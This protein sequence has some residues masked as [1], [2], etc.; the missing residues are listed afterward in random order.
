MNILI[1]KHGLA[2]V[3]IVFLAYF[4]LLCV[5]KILGDN[6]FLSVLTYIAFAV[7]FSFGYWLVL[8]TGNPMSKVNVQRNSQ[9]CNGISSS[10]GRQSGMDILRIVA[11]AEVILIHL[12][13]NGYY[14]TPLMGTRMFFLTIIRWILITCVP[15]FFLISGY[16]MKDK[17]PCLAFYRKIVLL[18][19][20]YIGGFLIIY[21]YNA[22]ILKQAT[23][24]STIIA[25]ILNY[26]VSGF[27][28]QYV[29][30]FFLIPFLN[31]IWSQCRRKSMHQWL[32]VTFLMI[33]AVAPPFPILVPDIFNFIYPITYYFV[34]A[35]IA[36]YRPHINK[37]W[38]I[39]AIIL[40][41]TL[42]S[43][44]SYLNADANG[45]FDW[46]FMSY[47]Q[48][49]YQ[50][51]PVVVMT[52]MIALLC[53]DISIRAPR[54]RH[55]LSFF[56]GLS[57]EIYLF[58]LPVSVIICNWLGISTLDFP[59]KAC[60]FPLVTLGTLIL[61][62]LAGKLLQRGIRLMYKLVSRNHCN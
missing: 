2:T 39:G 1:R 27:V 45:M 53:Y 3:V 16:F 11:T 46:A 51:L 42:L 36:Q 6:I 21:T 19:A 50:I 57:F 10:N 32:L 24:L 41:G 56:S 59:H 22:L 52:T 44:G 5:S 61:A 26:S 58:G 7:L 12:F 48:L 31:M 34:G 43:I 37:F 47:G 38:L 33:T 8:R 62:G 35:Y 17:T 54:I 20:T 23:S 15:L 25:S 40:I 13:L 60:Y 29:V 49:G 4:A 30:L 14:T 28:K 9:E 55:F 18:I